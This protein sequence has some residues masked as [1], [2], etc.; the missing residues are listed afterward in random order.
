[1]DRRNLIKT[2]GLSV[3]SLPAM[4]I[5]KNTVIEAPK[6]RSIR[7]A[8][9]TDIHIQPELKAPQKLA[10]CF[11]HVQNLEDQPSLIING[12]DTIMDALTQSKSRVAV[13][14]DLWNSILKNE[15]S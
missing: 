9:L 12:G 5:I 13:Q 4:A 14:W 2:L 10:E 1:M 3:F 6:T 7:I 15:N 11:H 8:H